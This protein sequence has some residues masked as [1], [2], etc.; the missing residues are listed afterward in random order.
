MPDLLRVRVLVPS[1]IGREKAAVSPLR[2]AGK[3][4]EQW[5]SRN[6]NSHPTVAAL[7]GK[8]YTDSR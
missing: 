7:R 3:N 6:F 5:D 2:P 4:W 8:E 1:G